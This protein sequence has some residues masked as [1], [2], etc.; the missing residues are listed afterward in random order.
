VHTEELQVVAHVADH[1]DRLGTRC[2]GE[3]V[4]TARSAQPT[5]QHDELAYA[6][7]V[8]AI[9]P[10]KGLDGAKSRLAPA[11]AP[12]ERRRLVVDM[13]DR[14]L[15][16]C[17]ASTVITRTLL[18]TPEP[19]LA[20]DGVEVL[21][22]AGTGHPDAVAAGFADPRA[23]D[24]ALVIMADCPRVTAQ[25]LDALAEAARPVALAPSHD[26]GVNA[27]ALRDPALFTPVF[28]VPAAATIESARAAGLEPAVVHDPVLAFDVD[29]P[30]D[31]N[32]I[33]PPHPKAPA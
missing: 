1:G 25:S 3:S 26:G 15:A 24:G 8:L 33:P 28:G 31:L 27:L 12:D 22:D 14:V 5:R 6:H 11:L 30:E 32:T 18:V 21:R 29:R 4:D 7:S 19:D 10:V 20:R 2:T 13:L 23:R 9:V 17:A 16:A